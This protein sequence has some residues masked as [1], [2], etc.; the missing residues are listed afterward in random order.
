MPTITVT[1]IRVQGLYVDVTLSGLTPGTRYDLY[2]MRV[3]ADG[4]DESG[5]PVYGRVLPDRKTYWQTVGHRYG[6]EADAAE[7]VLRDYEPPMRP[8]SYFL[9]ETSRVGPHDYNWANG[10]YPLSRGDLGADVVHLSHLEQTTL[11]EYGDPLVDPQDLPGTLILR[12]TAELGLY[13][14]ACLYDLD[15]IRYTARGTEHP[16]MGR[17]YPLYV[18]DTREARRGTLTMITRDVAEYDAVREIVFPQSGRIAPV[19]VNAGSDNT[20]LLDD[21]LTIPLDIDVQQASQSSTQVRFVTVDFVEVDPTTPLV[22]RAGDNP[23]PTKP[24]ADFTRAPVSP[25]RGQ[26]VVFTDT[27]TGAVTGWK[28]DL[29]AA[30]G[31]QG[32]SGAGPHRVRYTKTGKVLVKLRVSGP[33]GSSV[34][35]KRVKVV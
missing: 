18:A 13:T 22:V 29:R 21:M 20:L 32:P 34:V 6:W 4:E 33:G 25:Q 8:F 9:V 1:D 10:D 11:D 12:S 30:K 16:V 17:Q 35:E 19:A 14:R 2:R 28:W 3:N 31:W 5:D 15:D 7:S 27:S 26:P 24:R 23:D